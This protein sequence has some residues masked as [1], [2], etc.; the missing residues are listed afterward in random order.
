MSAESAHSWRQMGVNFAQDA[1]LALGLL[2]LDQDRAIMDEMMAYLPVALW[3][4]HPVRIPSNDLFA[5]KTA[6]AATAIL[7]EAVSLLPALGPNSTVCFG[8]TS[9]AMA[10]GPADISATLRGI[11]PEINVIDPASSVLAALRAFGVNRIAVLSPYIDDTNAVFDAFLPRHG[12]AI[13]NRGSFKLVNEAAIPDISPQ[14]I[15]DA[16]VSIAKGAE[17]LFITCTGLRCS[18][19]ISAI[20]NATDIPVVASCQAMAW[21]AWSRHPR[22]HIPVGLGSL[23]GRI[24]DGAA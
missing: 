13:V 2:C 17:A 10:L 6:K 12:I 15:Y 22:T 7:A 4:L 5:C 16:G 20:E 19:V 8:C 11:R 21:D 14:A 24:H 23:F 9:S 18:S 1:R 3:A